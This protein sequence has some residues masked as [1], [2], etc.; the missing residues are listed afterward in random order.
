[1]VVT[2]KS[3]IH[4]SDIRLVRLAVCATVLTISCNKPHEENAMPE[5]SKTIGADLVIIHARIWVGR[6]PFAD[7]AVR[8]M[9]AADPQPTAIAVHGQH[10]IAVGDDA[11][12]RSTYVGPRTRV[13][14]AGGRR[15]IP[16]ITDSHTHIISGGFQLARVELRDV[17]G[18]D[19]FIAKVKREV[20]SRKSGEWVQGGRW[21]VESWANPEMPHRAWL[22]S[23]SI[24]TPI[25]LSRMDGH[26]ALVNSAALMR[27]G[28]DANGPADPVGGE[29]ERDPNTRKPTGI[30]KESAMD[31][32]TRLI[33]PPDAAQRRDALNRAM[34]HANSLGVTSVHDMSDWDDLAVFEPAAKEKTLTVRVTSYVQSENWPAM[35]KP[36]KEVRARLQYGREF[37]IAGLK[38]YMDGS[39]G[40]RTAYMR[41][42]FVDCSHNEAYPR[43]QLTAFAGS[44]EKLQMVISEADFVY[45]MQA[46]IHAIG[47]QAN[48]LALQCESWQEDSHHGNGLRLRIEHAQ[49]LLRGDIA[50]FAR[51][52]VIASMQPFHKADDARY[53]EKAIG[54]ERL[55]GSYAFRSLL[56]AGALLIFGSDWPV[57][58]LNP[59]AGMHTAVTARAL[60]GTIF[61]PEESITVEEALVA[62]TSAPAL[63]I[64][65]QDNLGQIKPTML[66]DLVI[67]T[68]DPF[69]VA[70]EKLT[71]IT[72]HTTIM[73]GNVVYER[74]N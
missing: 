11:S 27:A 61:M 38:G 16:G 74:G 67:L 29:I 66:A 37:N 44:L 53:V 17:S 36:L 3:M 35:F 1:M 32:I 21:S 15:V 4:L 7:A 25:F 22:D 42:P 30:L 50:E 63:A 41:E 18:K 69:T 51:R 56:D 73:N 71:D 64:S 31:L 28:I 49:H 2:R 6:G 57:V 14:D 10:I 60:D 72:A 55:K 8:A 59:F 20:E 13:I 23:F 24:D 40:S 47:D 58:T 68:A 54:K 12:I 26:S 65:Q 33:P 34:K 39:M 9:L 70:P 5:P 19:E 62:Y 48:H 46:A 43:G 52:H 45:R